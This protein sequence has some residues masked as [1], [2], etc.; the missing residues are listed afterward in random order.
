[1]KNKMK[2]FLPILIAPLILAACSSDQEDQES[3]SQDDNTEEVEGQQGQAG[4]EASEESDQ[5]EA[6]QEAQYTLNEESFRIE[7]IEGSGADS[8]VVLM[9]FD[10]APDNYALEIAEILHDHDVPAIFFVNAMYLDDQEGQD[11]LQAIHDMGFEIG[12]HTY[13][14]PNLQEIS[15]EAQ[16]AEIVD[17]NDRVEELIG[18][19][20]RFFRP[21]FGAQTDYSYQVAEEEGMQSMNWSYGYDWE[22]QYQ[23]PDALADIM[24]N[25][26]FLSDGANLLMHDREWT[27]DAVEDIIFGFEEK[28]YGFVDPSL[29][30]SGNK[31]AA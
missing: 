11:Q 31:D 28:G 6:D 27:K 25:S 21:P 22:S 10:D 13:N 7:P 12:N 16:R 24:V 4:Q 30:E 2:G 19:R 23:D 15:E 17:T 5:A 26:E 18:V 9:T 20:P 3:E 14:H 29:I 8:Q 1:M